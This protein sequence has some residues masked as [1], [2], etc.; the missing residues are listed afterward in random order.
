[1]QRTAIGHIHLLTPP[2]NSQQWYSTLHR[3]SQQLK[4]GGIT[5]G[6]VGRYTVVA[7]VVLWFYVGRATR[8]QQAIYSTQ[9]FFDIKP[10]TE[11]RNHHR[12][13]IGTVN[14]AIDVF[15][16]H[17]I[18]WMGVNLLATGGYAN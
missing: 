14:N 12:H 15:L 7:P 18:K 17:D 9:Q 10:V 11:R 5:V 1:M 6:I 3:S 8:Q 4:C 2:A 13:R 16:T